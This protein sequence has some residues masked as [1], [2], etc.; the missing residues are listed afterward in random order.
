[1]VY[2]RSVGSLNDAMWM[3]SFVL[4]TLNRNLCS[5][6]AETFFVDIDAGEMF[7]NFVLHNYVQLY[8]RA[9]C[10]SYFPLEDGAK[11]WEAWQ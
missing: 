2:V 3:P 7:L 8:A 5:V 11:V 9:D 6:V 1:M 10:T 4:P